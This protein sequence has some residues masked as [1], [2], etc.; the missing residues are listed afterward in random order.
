[1]SDEELAAERAKAHEA[2]AAT[3]VAAART[4]P[5]G[6]TGGAMK[7]TLAW[8]AVGVPLAWGVWMTLTKA[9]PLFRIG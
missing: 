4:V 1:M 9:L 6:D 8:L 7:V 5:G 2:A 3:A